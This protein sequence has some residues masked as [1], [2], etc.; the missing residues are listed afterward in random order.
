MSKHAS[1]LPSSRPC[2]GPKREAGRRV[3]PPKLPGFSPR[4]WSPDHSTSFPT[5]PASAVCPWDPH[6]ALRPA[7]PS[8]LTLG[9][10]N[11]LSVGMK[12]M[13]TVCLVLGCRR[14]PRRRQSPGHLR[15]C[16]VCSSTRSAN[17]SQRH[18]PVPSH[19]ASRESSQQPESDSPLTGRQPTEARRG[20]WRQVGRDGAGSR[21]QAALIPNA[22]LFL[23]IAL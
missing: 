11:S 21:T 16:S 14:G 22:P 7:S 4:P 5:K 19:A 8:P 1:S 20:S 18:R 9:D 17:L 6:H 2:R 10:L 23:R 15:L 13:P 3:K 12:W